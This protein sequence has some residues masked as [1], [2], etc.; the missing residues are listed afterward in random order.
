MPAVTDLVQRESALEA[1]DVA[2]C[3][4]AAG[5]GTLVV[6]RGP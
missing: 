1:L 4:G 6:F 2:L 3:S 5:R